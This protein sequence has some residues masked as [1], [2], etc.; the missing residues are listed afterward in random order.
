ML[1]VLE[2][3]HCAGS[4]GRSRDESDG[5]TYNRDELLQGPSPKFA[6]IC[7]W[8]LPLTYAKFGAAQGQNDHSRITILLIKIMILIV[9]F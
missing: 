1:G 6:L 3:G 7:P 9:T 5:E 4:K 2:N 8:P